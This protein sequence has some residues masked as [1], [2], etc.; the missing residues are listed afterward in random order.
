LSV[1]LKTAGSQLVGQQVGVWSVGSVG[2]KVGQSAVGR[3]VGLSSVGSVGRSG[4]RSV[5]L[6]WVGR[7]TTRGPGMIAEQ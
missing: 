7:R 2:Q 1:I 5:G 6:Q 4:G 3:T